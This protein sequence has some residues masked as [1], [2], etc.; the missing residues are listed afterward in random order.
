M[1]KVCPML[2]T[3]NTHFMNTEQHSSPDPVLLQTLTRRSL[4]RRAALVGVAGMGLLGIAACGGESSPRAE[5]NAKADL[6]TACPD[7]AALS[8]TEVATRKALNYVDQ[9]ADPARLCSGCRLFKQPEQNAACG[10][11]QVVVGPIAP[12]GSCSAW[13]ALG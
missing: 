7:S 11:C 12:G 1:K 13:V 8:A 6:S 2:F 5:S 4:F 3:S 9:S 10:G